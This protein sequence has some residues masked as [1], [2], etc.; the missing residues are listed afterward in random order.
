MLHQKALKQRPLSSRKPQQKIDQS[1]Y[2]PTFPA[3]HVVRIKEG[4]RPTPKRSYILDSNVLFSDPNAIF[5]FKEHDV[6]IVSEVLEELDRHKIGNDD[7]HR[8]VREVLRTLRAIFSQAGKSAGDGVSLEKFSGGLATGKIF[9]QECPTSD[10]K[11]DG[12]ILETV[13]ML[14]GKERPDPVLV[15]K[16]NNMALRAIT[17]GMVVED[18]HTDIVVEDPDRLLY[19]GTKELPL[20]F[21]DDQMGGIE[22]WKEEGH[23]FYRIQGSFAKDLL[24][25]QFV[26]STEGKKF[27]AQVV[28]KEGR[29][30]VI[31]RSTTNY[32]H[33]P[34]WGINARN[35]EQNF[36]CN[37]LMNPKIHCVS[38]SGTA[39][40]GKTFLSISTALEQTIEKKLYSEI[41]FTRET[42]SAGKDIGFLPGTEEEKMEPWLG[43]L[44]DN[45][46]V[47]C[48]PREP[49]EKDGKRLDDHWKKNTTMELIRDKLQIRSLGF[50]RGRTFV[51]KFVIV[52]EVQNLT[53]KQVKTLVTRA[54][55]GT[56]MI[57]MG[58]LAQIDTP[59]ITEG[60]SGLAYLI[61]RFKGWDH[62]GH[63][64]LQRGERSLLADYG[65]EVL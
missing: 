7:K 18:Y 30:G 12:I 37:L 31:L 45:L 44:R 58:N 51:E 15:T 54:G 28:K 50:M 34:V 13:S 65:N 42:V 41:I 57:F 47:L 59:Y 16:D 48:N 1:P 23:T 46:E 35:R 29:G 53:P 43:A 24:M 2:R 5:R 20:G 63:I 25:N 21:F 33:R 60:S 9:L 26:Y 52:D 38:I 61:D 17:K 64:T 39:G 11:G 62:Y 27:D 10:K 49:I 4:T 56:K 36:L 14:T 8:N 19:T 40:S 6:I 22:S 55:N 3:P 32:L